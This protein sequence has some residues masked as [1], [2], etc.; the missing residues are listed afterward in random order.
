[1][2]LRLESHGAAVVDLQ[3]RLNDLGYPTDD[4]TGTFGAD[5]QSAVRAF[6]T[7]RGLRCD[8][9]C[10]EQTWA[11]M[12]EAGYR[13]GDRLLYLKRPMFRGDDVAELQRRLGGLGFDAGRV[14]G[15]F[16]PQTGVA[17]KDFQRN[18]GVTLDDAI[19]GRDTLRV[20]LG[21]SGR[22]NGE[23]VS[24]VRER[25]RLLEAPRTLVG[26]RVV[27]GETGGLS[28]LAD[29]VRRALI[30]A[31]C[32][33]ST[34][35]DPDE[36]A[37][38]RQANQLGAEVYLGLRL[39]PETPGCEADYFVGHNGIGSVGGRR[40][41]EAVQ[42]IVPA[43]LGIPELGVRGMRIPVLRETRM[44]AVLACLGPP[45]IVV[46]RAGDVAAS[47][48][49]ALAAWVSAPCDEASDG[50]FPEP[51]GDRSGLARS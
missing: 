44:P 29:S 41:A 22:I 10:G 39:E 47:L 24:G 36:S 25:Q 35:H 3:G 43:A 2:T 9:V 1:M 42:A 40:L 7:A 28:S 34:L 12:V 48:T 32:S 46:E 21:L 51:T 33:V 38:A 49:D 30:R 13:L 14:D 37:Q 11:A 4:P 16:G 18:V 15:I 26:R 23:V 31:G 5:T 27:V 20:L 6:Q 8:G 50:A 19:V 45:V 17:L